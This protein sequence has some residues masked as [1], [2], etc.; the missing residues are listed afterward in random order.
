MKNQKIYWIMATKFNI[1]KRAMLEALEKSLGVVTTAAKVVGIDRTTHYKWM[2]S[3]KKYKKA[4][5]NI[6]NV[7]LDFVESKLFKSIEKGRDAPII[8]YLKTKGK[9]RGY[10]ERQ[11]ITG[12]D[13]EILGGSPTIIVNASNVSPIKDEKEIKDE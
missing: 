4:V 9:K 10:I 11:E 2:T 7:A 6:D 1:Q 8:F 3:D 12:L 13:G 5:E